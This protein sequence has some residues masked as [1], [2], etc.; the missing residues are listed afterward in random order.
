MGKLSR[1]ILRWSL[2]ALVF[3]LLSG[4][5]IFLSAG[6]LDWREG[7]VFLGLLVFIQ[8]LNLAVLAVVD[9]DL[10][11]ERSD[12]Q[13]GTK[14]WDRVLVRIVALLGP[15]VTIVAAGLDERWS[16]SPPFPTWLWLLG[17]GLA[18]LG[19]VLGLWA[20]T[21]N[22]FFSGTVRIQSE[23]GHHVVSSGPYRFVRHPG[24]AGGLLFDLAAP[25]ALASWWA[26]L[27]A[28]ITVA[29]LGLRTWLEDQTLLNELDGYR[30]YAQRV[31]FR[32]LPGIW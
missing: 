29:F 7:Q 5:A 1:G 15:L 2:K 30:G 14:P 9:P 20:M 19:S 17:I 24:Y 32:L 22:H 28:V 21:T 12:V 10:L 11:L 23:R 13:E 3:L 31:R 16:W 27:P 4:S 8:L 26:L 6:K 18:L 25:L